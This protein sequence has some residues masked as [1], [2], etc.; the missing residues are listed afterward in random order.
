[1]AYRPPTLF[2]KNLDQRV[3]T[4]PPLPPV[5]TAVVGGADL[6][7]E[8]IISYEAE[9]Q[10]WY[11]KHRLRTRAALFYNHISDLISTR[12]LS[13]TLATLVNVPGSADIYGGELGAE[14]LATSWLTGFANYSYQEIHQ[15][16]TGRVRR[17]GPHNK[18]NVGLRGEWENGLSAEAIYHYYGSVTYPPGQSFTNLAQAGLI[19]LPDPTVG[20]YNL[21]NLR[22]GYRFWRQ[23]AAAGY[24]REAEVAVSAFNVLNDEHKEHPLGDLISRRVMGWLT[25][26]F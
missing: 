4:N 20:S 22:A 7:P 1:V 21:L 6:G 17:A 15:T 10:G 12:D 5:T 16:F 9:Y 2:E 18:F 19:T 14:F 13:P 3:T 23:K 8:Q 24:F 26:K 25:L 11:L